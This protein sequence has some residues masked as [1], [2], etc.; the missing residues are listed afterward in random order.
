MDTKE[1]REHGRELTTTRHNNGNVQTSDHEQPIATTKS[2]YI[3]LGH[4]PKTPAT[5]IRGQVVSI[6]DIVIH[7]LGC[8]GPGIS[9]KWVAMLNGEELTRHGAPL[10]AAARALLDRGAS[11]MATLRM[12]HQGSATVSMTG[13]IGALAKLTV[14]EDDSGPRVVRWQPLDRQLIAAE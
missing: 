7:S 8:S 1:R 3:E 13:V 14:V 10:Y 12:R 2:G 4:K 6:Y 5:A 11:P 9:E